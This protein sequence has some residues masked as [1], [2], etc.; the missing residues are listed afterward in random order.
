M[1]YFHV[2]DFVRAPL[3]GIRGTIISTE[4]IVCWVAISGRVLKRL[5][6]EDLVRWRKYK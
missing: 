5:R 2:G 1:R 3:W 6:Q 4:G